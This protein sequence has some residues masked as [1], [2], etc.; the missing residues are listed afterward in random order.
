MRPG[1][2]QLDEVRIELSGLPVPG[3]GRLVACALGL[4]IAALGIIQASVLSKKTRLLEAQ[5]D[6]DQARRILLGELVALEQAF[7]SA[8]V[9]PKT[10]EQAKR[11]L[12]DALARLEV[13]SPSPVVDSPSPVAG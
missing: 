9:G 1:Q 7:A 13:D 3:P 10:H 4:L 11:Q 2:G 6:R 12:L 5:E 8:A